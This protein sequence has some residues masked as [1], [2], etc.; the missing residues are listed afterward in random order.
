MVKCKDAQFINTHI[1][2]Q[3]HQSSESKKGDKHFFNSSQHKY[4][5]KISSTRNQAKRSQVK[6]KS[7]QTFFVMLLS[8]DEWFTYTRTKSIHPSNDCIHCGPKTYNTSKIRTQMHPNQSRSM[9]ITRL[10]QKGRNILSNSITTHTARS[11]SFLDVDFHQ[12]NFFLVYF[13]AS[14]RTIVFQGMTFKKP[15][16]NSAQH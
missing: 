6:P 4:W 12:P 9:Y 8:V 3:W 11:L 13:F 7:V 10:L 14:A 1:L 5:T 2:I 16:K 15:A